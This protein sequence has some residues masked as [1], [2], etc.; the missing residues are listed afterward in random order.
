L[1][2]KGKLL[3]DCIFNKFKE[4]GLTLELEVTRDKNR[5]KLLKF[6]ESNFEKNLIEIAKNFNDDF[7]RAINLNSYF[8]RK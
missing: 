3:A 6:I 5:F 8:S 2:R 1:K 4:E 7:N